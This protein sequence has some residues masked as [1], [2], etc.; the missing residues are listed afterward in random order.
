MLEYLEEANSIME[1][2]AERSFFAV[3]KIN[4]GELNS[5]TLWKKKPCTILV[6]QCNAAP[7]LCVTGISL[8]IQCISYYSTNIYQGNFLSCIGQ[9]PLIMS[10]WGGFVTWYLGKFIEGIFDFL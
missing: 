3:A 8:Y 4:M 5:Y 6:V 1:K 2:H 7:L 9:H 10:V